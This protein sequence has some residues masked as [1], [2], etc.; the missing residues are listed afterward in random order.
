MATFSKDTEE[1]TICSR[2][3]EVCVAK[4]EVRTQHAQI[5]STAL[6]YACVA[7]RFVSKNTKC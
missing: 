7:E 2:K 6:D 1:V 3:A 5:G 4:A